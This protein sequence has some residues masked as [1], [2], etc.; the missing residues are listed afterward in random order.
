MMDFQVA[1]AMRNDGKFITIT[2]LHLYMPRLNQLLWRDLWLN[3]PII[4]LKT[5]S[6]DKLFA[7]VSSISVVNQKKK[8]TT[9]R[10]LLLFSFAVF[11]Q[12]EL[13]RLNRS[14]FR[15]RF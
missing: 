8:Q 4:R 5:L 7:Q 13:R 15:L 1:K 6:N 2:E 10:G 3:I 14:R 11:G 9:K 12:F